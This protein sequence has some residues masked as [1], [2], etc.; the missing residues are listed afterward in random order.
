MSDDPFYTPGRKHAPP[1]PRPTESLW[2]VR[3]GN[4]Q[5]TCELR[6]HGESGVEAQILSDGELLIGRRFESRALAVQWAGE[7][8]KAI[9]R[10]DHDPRR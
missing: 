7:E 6:Y 4:H 2:T 1:V 8:R 9:E 3:K 10:D 5:M